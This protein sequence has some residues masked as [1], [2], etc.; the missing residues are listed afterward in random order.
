MNI[1]GLKE[2]NIIFISELEIFAMGHRVQKFK[3]WEPFYIGTND[4]PYYDERFTWEGKSNK[5]VQG[6]LLCILDYEF[7]V[8]S[9]AFLT[10]RPG[11]KSKAEATRT[12]F[13]DPMAKRI[14]QEIIPELEALFGKREG[15]VI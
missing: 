14:K 8:L 1:D 10:H 3:R 2:I 5:M 12:Q 11:I 7:A 13:T 4:E 6:Y 15:C 9:N